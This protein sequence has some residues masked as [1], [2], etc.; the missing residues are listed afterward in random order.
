MVISVAKV[1]LLYQPAS[2][3][4]LQM[5]DNPLICSLKHYLYVLDLLT[6]RLMRKNQMVNKH[7]ADL[8]TVLL[9]HQGVFQK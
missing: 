6:Y 5:R 2:S 3:L 7:R 9:S 8:I 1:P 4:P